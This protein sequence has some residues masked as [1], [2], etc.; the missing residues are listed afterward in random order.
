MP[1]DESLV[2]VMYFTYYV[3]KLSVRY[4]WTTNFPLLM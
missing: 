4:L 1:K 2:Q 3:E